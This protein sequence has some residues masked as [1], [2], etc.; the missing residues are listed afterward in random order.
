MMASIMI[1]PD[2]LRQ[3]AQTL[4]TLNSEHTANYAKMEQLVHALVT[5]WT[6]NAQQA[7]EAAFIDKKPEFQKFA[8]VISEFVQLMKNSA[9]KME[10]T[11]EELKSGM[12]VG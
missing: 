2:S 8:A 1:T 7:F 5:Q 9:L 10:Q 11:D 6:G 4:E 12:S 3:Q